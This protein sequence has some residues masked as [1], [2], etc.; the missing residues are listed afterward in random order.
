MECNK[1]KYYFLASNR[2]VNIGF[3]G[4][5]V[6]GFGKPVIGFIK[7]IIFCITHCNLRAYTQ[8]KMNTE[9]QELA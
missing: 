1:T 2:D 4:K 8:R 5:L 7:Q 3:L 6:I 9:F